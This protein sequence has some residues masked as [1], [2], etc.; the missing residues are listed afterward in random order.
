MRKRAARRAS[1]KFGFSQETSPS[2]F[3]HSHFLLPS[4]SQKKSPADVVEGMEEFLRGD[5][6]GAEFADDDAG[7]GVREHGAR[8]GS[9]RESAENGVAGAG[10]VE[11]LAA[12]GAALDARLAHTCVGDFKACRGNVEMT[13][14][15]F[16]EDAHSLFTTGD[17]H[18]AAAEMREQGA[19]G[20]FDGFFVGEGTRD[21]KAG[22]LSIADD[23]ARATIGIKARRFRL[24]ENGNFQLMRGAED[25]V[26]EVVGDETFVVVGKHERVEMPECGEKQT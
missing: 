14:R 5:A 7:G 9:E 21:V 3:H 6:G 16:F 2:V 20:F 25:A 18:G 11:D 19:A 23:G 24:H 26:G 12:G 13:G 10:D 22:F 17:D 1:W 4:S 15:R 8:G